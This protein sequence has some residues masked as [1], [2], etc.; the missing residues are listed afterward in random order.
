MNRTLSPVP[1]CTMEIRRNGTSIDYPQIG[2]V[3]HLR[4]Q[5]SINEAIVQLVES[6]IAEQQEKQ[7][8]HSFTEMIG[9]FEI[10]TNERSILSLTLSNYAYAY[11]HANGLTVMRSLTFDVETG[12]Q[13]ELNDL[14]L[15]GSPYVQRLSTLVKQQIKER[16][17]PVIGEFSGISPQQEFYIA[18]KTLVLYFQSIQIT[19]HYVG[20]PMFPI[21]VYQLEDIIDPDGP[22]ERML[23]A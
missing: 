7:G 5:R 2:H 16:N 8:V 14:F 19:P 12:K 18:D 20:I 10:K 23:P 3:T 9:L 13:Y 6:L 21:S 15:Q 22:L 1:I 4:V 17:I 11:P